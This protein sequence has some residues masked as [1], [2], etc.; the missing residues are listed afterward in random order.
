MKARKENRVYTITELEKASYLAQG[1][2]IQHDD[3][4]EE[5]PE[6]AT[7]SVKAY[8]ALEAKNR[9]LAAE[10]KALKAQLKK[11]DTGKA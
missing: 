4:S 8:E 6:N 2:T 10:L 7:V 1:Y 3:G 9:A 11:Q 5:K